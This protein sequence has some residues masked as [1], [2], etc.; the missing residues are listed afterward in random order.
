MCLCN[1]KTGNC[2]EKYGFLAFNSKSVIKYAYIFEYKSKWIYEDRNYEK[3]W[4]DVFTKDIERNPLCNSMIINDKFICK[5]GNLEGITDNLKSLLD[6][7]LPNGPQALDFHL[8]VFCKIDNRDKGNKVYKNILKYLTEIRPNL[9]I[10][11]SLY[12]SSDV[13]NRFVLT[14]SYVLEVGAGFNLFKNGKAENGSE[15]NYYYPLTIGNN[16]IFIGKLKKVEKVFS[17]SYQKECFRNFWG[18]KKNRLFDLIS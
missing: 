8:S 5:E 17:D 18:E 9:N 15:Y 11:L 4:K 2:A 12:T 7:L 13:H 3:G 1:N 16:E 6:V 10:L 14:N